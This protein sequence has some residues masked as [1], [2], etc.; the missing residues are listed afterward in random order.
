MLGTVL[1]KVAAAA[2]G[3]QGTVGGGVRHRIAVQI[4]KQFQRIGSFAH[5]TPLH[6]TCRHTQ[7]LMMYVTWIFVGHSSLPIYEG[8]LKIIKIKTK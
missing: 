3:R 5:V 1:E 2:P 4:G 8:H 6:R 7:Q